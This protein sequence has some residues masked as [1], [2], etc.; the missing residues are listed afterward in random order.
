MAAQEFHAKM[1][2]QTPKELDEI[3]EVEY[4]RE[5]IL[6]EAGI[7]SPAENAK[8]MALMA[9]YYAR[10]CERVGMYK[11]ARDSEFARLLKGD[12][13][14]K[15]GRAEALAYGGV[16]GTKAKYYENIAAGYLEI[17]NSLKKV[18]EFHEQSGKNNF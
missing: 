2:W 7:L 18:Q 11:S 13:D 9:H 14:M 16:A 6:Q 12:P 1:D 8:S 5:Q 17:V 10:M 15:I 3:A 4:I